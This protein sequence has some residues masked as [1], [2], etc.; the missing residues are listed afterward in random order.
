MTF[1]LEGER[2]EHRMIEHADVRRSDEM[3][4]VPETS[5]VR[6]AALDGTMDIKRDVGDRNRQRLPSAKYLVNRSIDPVWE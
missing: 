1:E 2:E 6:T 5:T 4:L 3:Q